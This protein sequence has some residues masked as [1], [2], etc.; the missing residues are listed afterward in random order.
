MVYKKREKFPTELGGYSDSEGDSD[1]SAWR[2]VG[3]GSGQ[4]WMDWG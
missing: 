4:C 1:L 3:P 2:G